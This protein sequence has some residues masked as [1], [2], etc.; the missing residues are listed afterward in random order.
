MKMESDVLKYKVENK[1]I[2]PPRMERDKYPFS[3][4]KVGQSFY[5]VPTGI[6]DLIKLRNAA[7][8]YGNRN[9]VKFSI[10]R[11]GEGYRCGRIK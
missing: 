10:V 7:V 3:K 8:H 6:N 1:P 2:T 5:F 9:E 4:M 11:D